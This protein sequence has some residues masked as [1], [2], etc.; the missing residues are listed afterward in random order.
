MSV[1]PVHFHKSKVYDNSNI[2][3]LLVPALIFFIVITIYLTTIQIPN[4]PK[5]VAS[6]AKSDVLGEE[7]VDNSENIDLEY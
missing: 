4:N 2:I 1:T 6:T 5:S 7:H 3:L